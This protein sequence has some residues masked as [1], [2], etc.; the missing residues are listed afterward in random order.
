M[1][2]ACLPSYIGFTRDFAS[3]RIHSSDEAVGCRIHQRNAG[4]EEAMEIL[5]R[6][7]STTVIEHRKYRTAFWKCGAFLME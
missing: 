5:K 1:W 2:Y 3:F 7:Q 4:K 6:N